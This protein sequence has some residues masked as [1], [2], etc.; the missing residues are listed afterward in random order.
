LQLFGHEGG[1]SIS[2]PDSRSDASLRVT[3]ELAGE[4]VEVVPSLPVAPR[5][6]DY[7]R[8]VAAFIA[9]IRAGAPSPAPAEQG[10]FIMQ[11]IDALYRSAEAGREVV[12]G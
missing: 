11:I 12:I 10:L 3:T 9:A 5:G 1:A 4:V 6:D 8:E 2:M 7:D